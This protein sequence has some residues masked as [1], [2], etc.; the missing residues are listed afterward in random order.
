MAS[1]ILVG[2]HYHSCLVGTD[3]V[4][5]TVASE[6]C[7]AEYEGNLT[8]IDDLARLEEVCNFTFVSCMP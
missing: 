2:R 3:L 7:N 1:E 4:S 8:L 6:L 5:Q